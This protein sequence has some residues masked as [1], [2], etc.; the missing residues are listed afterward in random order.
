MVKS[1]LKSKLKSKKVD[2]NNYISMILLTIIL[3]LGIKYI[4]NNQFICKLCSNQIEIMKNEE[5][6][7]LDHY[8]NIP[9]EIDNI[10]ISESTKKHFQYS[11]LNTN[12]L[13][14]IIDM[15]KD[16]YEPPG[17]EGQGGA[18]YVK[19]GENTIQPIIELIN[20]WKGSIISSIDYHPQGH[21]SFLDTE[22]NQCSGPYPPH[23]IWGTEGAKLSEGIVNALNESKNKKSS[24]IIYKGF[25]NTF[26]SYG[27]THYGLP[28]CGRIFNQCS[29]YKNNEIVNKMQIMTGGYLLGNEK[30]SS[31]VKYPTEKEMNIHQTNIQLQNKQNYQSVSDYLNNELN[32][33]KRI[34][35]VGLAGD[36]CVLDTV[37][38]LID[39]YIGENIEIYLVLNH[40][41]FAWIPEEFIP[42]GNPRLSFNGGY[43]LTPP[44]NIIGIGI[45]HLCR[46]GDICN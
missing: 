9:C 5:C 20:Q 35:V 7:F 25:M 1:K 33:I 10:N 42:E 18:F 12:D 2:E 24:K 4:I 3:F 36:F 22:F 39:M 32:N 38:N 27:A 31:N 41:R 15:Q 26:D 43:F 11:N 19:E 45:N 21:C 17:K 28:G 13:L 8:L 37:K 44:E 34:F 14:F 29:K 23:C 16:F 40:T 30:D 6:T 46:I